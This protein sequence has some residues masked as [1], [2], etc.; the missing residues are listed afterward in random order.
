MGSHCLDC[1]VANDS[2]TI[3]V[4]YNFQKG[5]PQVKIIIGNA[6]NI[7]QLNTVMKG[8]DV[9]YHFAA[10]ADISKAAFEPIVSIFMT[11]NLPFILGS[12]LISILLFLKEKIVCTRDMITCYL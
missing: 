7:D 4:F 8:H 12:W 6:K 1:F 10:N 2:N 9:V 3:T 11:I 5:R